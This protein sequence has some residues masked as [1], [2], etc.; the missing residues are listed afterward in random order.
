MPSQKT[1]PTYMKTIKTIF[2]VIG[3]ITISFLIALWITTALSSIG[4][5]W[6]DKN[7]GERIVTGLVY[8]GIDTRNEYATLATFT[9]F[10]LAIGLSWKLANWMNIPSTSST[11]SLPGF[12]RKPKTEKDNPILG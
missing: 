6:N 7:I 11:P 4:D 8:L 9:V 2:M 1:P 10:V 5:F 12:I 3:F